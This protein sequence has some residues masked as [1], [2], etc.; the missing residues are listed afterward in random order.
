LSPHVATVAGE[1]IH[2][3]VLEE[4]LALLRRGPRSRHIP[5]PGSPGYAD[6]CRWVVRDLVTEAVLEHEAGARG[7]TEL[8]QLVLAVT[9]EVAVSADEIRAY[10]ERNPDLYRRTATIISYEEA[11]HSIEEELLLAAR[12]RAFDRWLEGRR[13]ALAVVQPVYAHPADPS[14]GF[15]SHRH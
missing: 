5:S 15:P 6:A 7:L 13:Q 11:K 8:S 14:H 2:V 9:E 12:I 3:S 10:Y 1:P 4:R